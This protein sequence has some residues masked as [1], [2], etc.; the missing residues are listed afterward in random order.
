[1]QSFLAVI[2]SLGLEPGDDEELQRRKR[3]LTLT[4]IAKWMLCPIWI[5]SYGLL[6][7]RLAALMPLAYMVLSAL[8][9]LWFF[10]NKRFDSF[11]F[12]QV[13]LILVLPFCLQWSLGGFVASSC[14]VLWSLL[15]PVTCLFFGD[16]DESLRWFMAYVALLI[17]SV[18]ADPWLARLA[19]AV[20]RNIELLFFVLNVTCVSAL[21]FIAIRTYQVVINQQ[22]GELTR[23]YK[24]TKDAH[25][26]ATD[27]LHVILPAPIV[28]EL[29]ATNSVR[30]RRHEEVAIL[31][32]DIAGFTQYCDGR[33]P[34]EVV[35]KLQKVVEAYERLTVRYRLQ[36][37]KTIGDCFM[38]AAGLIHPAD[39]PVLN[40]LRCGIEMAEVVADIDPTWKVR[41]GMHV[42][43][44]VAGVLGNMQYQ[45]D[46]WGD[47]VN[48]ASRMESNGVVGS[49]TLSPEAYQRVSDLCECESL[50]LIPVRGKR[51]IEIFRFRNWRPIMFSS[52]TY[53]SLPMSPISMADAFG[54]PPTSGADA[55]DLP[56]ATP[57]PAA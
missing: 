44:V 16:I 38:A 12:R 56:A 27:L 54:L 17:A 13:L 37:I 28:E 9:A 19:P 32:C 25:Q 31:F 8:S 45:Y 24:E 26:R 43:P 57:Q 15:A 18:F 52:G 11:R 30:A 2:G 46:I 3:H 36:K 20:P 34:T 48:T 47:S 29:V 10:H 50:G 41:V 5:A 53:A 22:A 39:N 40:C 51:D 42:G 7:L 1:M 6:G 49:V 4:A 33:E 35:A 14:V 21:T 23:L 55:I